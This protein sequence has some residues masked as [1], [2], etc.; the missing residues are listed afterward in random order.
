[1]AVAP[2]ADA[3]TVG[4]V[5]YFFTAHNETPADGNLT[6]QCVT[7]LKWFFAQM[8][9]IPNPFGARGDARYVGKRLVAEG[10]AV[11]VPYADR[12]EGDVICYEYGT[13]GHIAL[14]L[15]G[16]RVFEENVNWAGVASKIV[17]GDRVYASRIGSENEAW[18][19]DAHVYRIKSYNDEGASMGKVGLE[20]ARILTFGLLGRNGTDGVP[21]ALGGTTDGDLNANHVN[22]EFNFDYIRGLYNSGEGQNWRAVRLPELNRKAGIYDKLQPQLDA[23]HNSIAELNAQVA[24]LS[25]RPT[26]EE[27]DALTKS[28]AEANKKAQEAQTALEKVN[29]ERQADVETGNS[30]LRWLGNQLNKLKGN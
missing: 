27:L 4:R 7:L 30:F 14:Q 24:A 11:E 28:A 23:A 22:Q 21:N 17:D 5:N 10:L 15:S 13:Y 3:Y 16:G 9:S 20:M 2:D 1:M 19:H 12:R 25:K 26:Q 18:R 8:T 29:Q 6:G